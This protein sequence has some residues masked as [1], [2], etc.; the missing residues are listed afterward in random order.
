MDQADFAE[1]V[2]QDASEVK[3][4]QETDSIDIIDN[5]RFH[6]TFSIQTYGDMSEANERLRRIDN[7]LEELEI[8][9]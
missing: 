4:R 1:L 6:I 2:K 3:G 7:L 8:E 5:I 9:G